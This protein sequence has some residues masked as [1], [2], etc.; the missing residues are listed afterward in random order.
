MLY[1]YYYYRSKWPDQ[2]GEQVRHRQPCSNISKNGY[3]FIFSRI[4]HFNFILFS[5]RVDDA[6]KTNRKKVQLYPRSCWW[7]DLVI[8]LDK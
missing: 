5:S 4:A 3:G 8:D 6:S 1:Y 7:F 2:Q